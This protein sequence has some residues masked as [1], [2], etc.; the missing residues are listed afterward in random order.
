M[1]GAFSAFVRAAVLDYDERVVGGGG[2]TPIEEFGICNGMRRP[3]CSTCYPEGPPTQDAWLRFVADV[4]PSHLEANR[5]GKVELHYALKEL[6]DSIEPKPA[7]PR[8]DEVTGKFPEPLTF[9]QKLIR[10]LAK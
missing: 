1:R 6:H 9:W 3:T 5:D 7:T 4:R 10:K 2:H 8:V